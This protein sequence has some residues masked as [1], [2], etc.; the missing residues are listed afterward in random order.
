VEAYW[1]EILRFP[2]FPD[3]QLTDGSEAVKPYAPAAFH[4]IR[5]QV[6]IINVVYVLD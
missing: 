2:H 4:P 5:I 1:V 6:L 3:N